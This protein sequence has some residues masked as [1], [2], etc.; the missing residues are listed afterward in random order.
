MNPRLREFER[1]SG[2]EIYGLGARREMW[3]Q[4]LE[5]YAELVVEECTTVIEK[6]L[7]KGIG[8]N[9]SRAVRRHFDIDQ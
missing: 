6:N 1:E 5:K 4:A 9:T 2:L 3:E 7:Y 8:W